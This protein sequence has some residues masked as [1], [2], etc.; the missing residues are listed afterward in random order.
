LEL[1]ECLF[2]GAGH[3]CVGIHSQNKRPAPC[4]SDFL[5]S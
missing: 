3:A 4:P 5:E 2:A 1:V